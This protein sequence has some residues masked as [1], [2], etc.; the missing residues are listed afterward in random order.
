V[1]VGQSV[2]IMKHMRLRDRKRQLALTSLGVLTAALGFWWIIRF[3]VPQTLEDADKWASVLAALLA[4]VGI[5]ASSVVWIFRSTQPILAPSGVE[6]AAPNPEVVDIGKI[7][8]IQRQSSLLRTQDA[9]WGLGVSKQ[10]IQRL[11]DLDIADGSDLDLPHRGLTVVTGELGAGKSFFA[12]RLH[13]QHIDGVMSSRDTWPSMLFARDLIGADLNAAILETGPA[14]WSGPRHVVI[15]GCDEVSRDDAMRILRAARAFAGMNQDSRIILFSRPGYL[16]VAEAL[17]LPPMTDEAVGQLMS[18]VAGNEIEI[19][20]ISWQLHDVVRRPLFAILYARLDYRQLRSNTTTGLL[21]TMVEEVLHRDRA[22][23]EQLFST[24]RSLASRTMTHRGRLPSAEAGPLDRREELL[25]TRLVVIRDSVVQFAAPVIEQ[26][27]AAQALL[28]GEI[29]VTEQLDSLRIWESWRPAWV[30]AVATGGWADATRLVTALAERFPGAAAWLV[31]QAIPDAIP[32]NGE[33]PDKLDLYTIEQRLQQAFDVWYQAMSE[34]ASVAIPSNDA[35]QIVVRY[36]RSGRLFLGI[37]LGDMP[38]SQERIAEGMQ[39]FDRAEGWWLR[40]EICAG[41]LPAWPWR[42]T[43][44]LAGGIISRAIE[45]LAKY[46]SAPSLSDEQLWASVKHIAPTSVRYRLTRS[47]VRDK[48]KEVIIAEIDRHLKRFQDDQPVRYYLN[49]REYRNEDLIDIREHVLGASAT[50]LRDP[51]PTV[52]WPDSKG[53][54]PQHNIDQLIER[55]HAVYSA[56]F[57]AYAYIVH[58]WLPQ[59]SDTLELSIL[60]PIR[61]KAYVNADHRGPRIDLEL[62]PAPSGSYDEIDLENGEPPPRTWDET[63]RE[64]HRFANDMEQYRPE[65]AAW[66]HG[67]GLHS[68]LDVFG[69]RPATRMA[70]RWLWEDLR[71]IHI[72]ESNTPSFNF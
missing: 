15:D 3:L 13:R 42:T 23:S 63:K 65:S 60:L 2:S 19:R 55:T 26:Y 51:W 71:D 14:D 20:T 62:W 37:W 66:V 16:S 44:D 29:D 6:D 4:Y 50:S 46:A 43:K 47:T 72:V 39:I 48:D 57:A 36:Y 56:A 27:F 35:P 53:P 54:W 7:L 18:A 24:L 40:G 70:Y 38:P 58:R 22:I 49:G 10:A 34:I 68:V 32:A 64:Y 9:W 69:D 45:K 5:T 41:N 33:N 12:E 17:P 52:D 8:E 11:S 28:R 25:S 31:H 67:F 21:A 30:M 59:F 1:A 61:M